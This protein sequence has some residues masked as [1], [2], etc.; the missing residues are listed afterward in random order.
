MGQSSQRVTRFRAFGAA[1]LKGPAG[2]D[3]RSVLARPKLLGLLSY[4]AAA[5]PRGFQR[6]DTITGLLWGE[7]S[8]E[9]ARGA[10]R[11]ALYHLRQ[12]LGEGVVVTRG[13]EEV[14][15]DAERFWSD[16]AAFEDAL[17]RGAREEAV[18]LYRG[19]LLHGFY[20]SGALEFEHWLDGRREELREKARVAAWDLAMGAEA[21]ENASD[22]ARWARQ[23][24]RLAPLD[25]E[26]V[27][28]VIELL[29]RL[30]DRSGAVREYEAFAARMAEELELEPAAAT[31]ALI[32]SVRSRGVVELSEVASEPAPTLGGEVS[33]G[34]APS[35]PVSRPAMEGDVGGG[36]GARL[37]ATRAFRLGLVAGAALVI[38]LGIVWAFSARNGGGER[39]DERR[40]VVAIFE[41]RTGEPDLDP[42]GR[43]AADWVTEGL[44][45]I[46]VVDVVPS[47]TGLAPRPDVS[48]GG[49]SS[50]IDVRALAEAM[51]AGTVIAGA[52]YRSGDSLEFQ[53]Q[54]V[55]ARSGEL[56]SAVEP[57]GGPLDAPGPVVDALR[58]RVVG[59]VATVFDSRL[60]S[61]AAGGRPPS[62]EAYR[63]Y[64]EGH[65]AF[66]SGPQLRQALTFFYRAVAL[67][68]LFIDPRF[69]LVLVHAN[70]GEYHAADSNAHLLVP[71][72]PRMSTYQRTTLDWLLAA[73]R[74]DRAAA[75]EAAR[76]R[77]GLD[78]GVEALKANRPRETVA[79]LAS[80]PVLPEWFFQWLT[81]MEAYHVL[82]DYRDELDEVRRGREAY[83]QRMRMLDVEVRAL[84]ALG[85]INDMNR[86]LEES[87]LLP[88][89]DGMLA[90]NVMMNAA[91]ELRA[92]GLPA[93]SFEAADRAIRWHLSRP[94]IEA[95]SWGHRF[96]LARAYYIRERWDDAWK[97]FE[98]LALEAPA[99]PDAQLF[100]GVLAARRGDRA[101][102][103]RVE[104]YLAGL[105]ESGLFGRNI[106]MQARIASQL[107]DRERAVVLLR[108]AYARGHA[109]SIFLH[110]EMDL[111]PLRDYLPFQ[112]FIEP[113]G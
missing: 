109:F 51:D 81:L 13:D 62:L 21:A 112:Q 89:N 32:E 104:E 47:T 43:M 68:S 85:R 54:V 40:V 33:E 29:G 80:A 82:G 106:Y 45:Q 94:T 91:E 59:T 2:S 56:L 53:A 18:D 38:G 103:L 96:R 70:L 74:G 46:E 113:K 72:R 50:A 61:P 107:G 8:Q 76:A 34:P 49:D 67:D 100:V 60:I 41:N 48:D 105:D 17:E 58:Q 71:H 78:V 88:P 12:F 64:L 4:L 26:M 86:R 36:P 44:A 52:Y 93:A 99:S 11:Q 83:P 22:A 57:V 35:P 87:L 24:L 69:Y 84:A 108:E 65:R 66:H 19:D 9:R 15:L 75:L 79:A 39:L 30:G 10:L 101:T 27:R 98:E 5:T 28:Q 6:R 63:A 111:E 3:P 23:A 7:L 90:A 20:L 37:L 55:D 14:G 1:D 73:I 42:L 97:L 31:Q 16:V 92:H 25:E 77:G 95:A 110:R 102:A